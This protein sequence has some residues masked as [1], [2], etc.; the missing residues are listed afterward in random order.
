LFT[1]NV[2]LTQFIDPSQL[3]DEYGGKLKISDSTRIIPLKPEEVDKPNE[4]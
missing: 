4:A 1:H 3:A 2:E